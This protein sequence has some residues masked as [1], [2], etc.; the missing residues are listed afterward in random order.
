[1]AKVSVLGPERARAVAQVQ[2]LEAG[3]PEAG[4]RGGG[5]SLRAYVDGAGQS[6]LLHQAAIAPGASLRIAP[7]A[8]DAAAYVWRG[9][10]V[11][12]GVALAAGS[13]AVVERG[14]AVTLAVPAEAAQAAQVLVFAGTGAA[15]AD[16]DAGAGG[17]GGGAQVHLLP[18]AQVPRMAPE[19]G[20]SGVS[21]GLHADSACPTCSVWLHENHFPAG[22]DLS[23]EQAERGIHSHSEDE[24]IFVID[25]EIRLGSKGYGPGTALAIAADTLYGLTAGQLGLS[26]INFRAAMPGDIRFAHGPSISETGYWRERVPRPAYLAP[27]SA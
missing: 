27:A 2:G 24:I 22:M 10:V 25:G 4:G 17:A 8:G 7:E 6:I 20:S 18:A 23:A 12:G 5:A 19:P 9:A 21:G 16:T 1:M 3:S 26:F 11:A 15:R 14:G 13:S